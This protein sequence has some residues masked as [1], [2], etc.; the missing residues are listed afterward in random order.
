[1]KLDQI[2]TDELIRELDRRGKKDI[3]KPLDSPD[4][5]GL[6]QAC[7]NYLISLRDDGIAND[8]CDVYISEAALTA[9]YGEDVFDWISDVAD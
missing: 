3:P 5:S 1:M 7:K 4:L 8:D 6:I 2:S 9:I